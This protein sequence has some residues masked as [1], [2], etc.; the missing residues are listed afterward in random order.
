M[1][2]IVEYSKDSLTLD[3]KANALV[4]AEG[5]SYSDALVKASEQYPEL[6]QQAEVEKY[7]IENVNLDRQVKVYMETHPE[8]K[9]DYKETLL[10]IQSLEAAGISFFSKKRE[11]NSLDDIRKLY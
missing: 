5:I 9:M 3:A 6:T 4:K 2:K 10:H 8:S 7:A 1:P 11:I